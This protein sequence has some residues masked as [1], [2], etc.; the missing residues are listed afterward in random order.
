MVTLKGKG[1]VK[2]V[3]NRA[4]IPVTRISLLAQTPYPYYD[5]VKLLD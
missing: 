2:R 4:T 1:N 3:Y 5:W